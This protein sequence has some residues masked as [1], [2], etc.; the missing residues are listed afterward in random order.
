VSAPRDEPRLELAGGMPA[1]AIIVSSMLRAAN[2]LA[3]PRISFRDVT[4][5][6]YDPPPAPLVVFHSRVACHL[7]VASLRLCPFPARSR[8]PAR[9]QAESSGPAESRLSNETF[10][11]D[12]SIESSSPPRNSSG[13]GDCSG[14][15]FGAQ[16][17]RPPEGCEPSSRL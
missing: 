15:Q 2:C 5:R 11:L 17:S 10:P 14:S 4:R 6:P 13:K 12:R 7:S 3:I 8:V 1:A 9:F 16:F